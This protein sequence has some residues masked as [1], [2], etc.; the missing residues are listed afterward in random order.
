MTKVNLMFTKHNDYLKV[1]TFDV[2]MACEGCAN[3][4]KNG[5]SSKPLYLTWSI[6]VVGLDKSAITTHVAQNKVEV[7][8]D[9][10]ESQI[11]EVLISMNKCKR[12][13]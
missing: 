1:L 8:S 13:D 4:I 6:L 3:A 2:E 10:L 9:C 12:L 7:T 11:M 5:L